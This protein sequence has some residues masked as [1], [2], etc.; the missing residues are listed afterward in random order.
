MG[1]CRLVGEPGDGW[2]GA[3][4]VI[5]PAFH[6]PTANSRTLHLRVSEAECNP[7]VPIVGRL[8][9]AYVFFEPGRV[10]I[11][12]FIRKVEPSGSCAASSRLPSA[13]RRR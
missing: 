10:R 4:W 3:N 8:A 2:G 11:Q 1:D 6:A 9:P 13:R 7:T 5:D 12:M